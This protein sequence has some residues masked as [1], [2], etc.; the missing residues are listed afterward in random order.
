MIPTFIRQIQM[1]N[2]LSKC[3]CVSH[4]FP[5]G[6][7]TPV[8]NYTGLQC[9]YKYQNW[10]M[11]KEDLAKYCLSDCDGM[12]IRPYQS[13]KLTEVKTSSSKISQ[14]LSLRLLALPTLRHKRYVVRSLLDLVG[15]T[16]TISYFLGLQFYGIISV[17]IVISLVV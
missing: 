12:V 13:G 4:R 3:S 6:I 15:T 14:G 7:D 9:I 2:M 10:I 5:Y 11:A 1:E 8:C 16:K 17:K